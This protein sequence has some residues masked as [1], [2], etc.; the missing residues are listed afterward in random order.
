M[1]TTQLHN[2]KMKIKIIIIEF[3]SSSH[4]SLNDNIN[5]AS[6]NNSE[7]IENIFQNEYSLTIN[8]NQE[9]N[10]NEKSTEHQKSM[11]S[12]ATEKLI[13]S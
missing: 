12:K 3:V 7:S 6:N 11:S 13:M 2:L 10:D 4:K 1:M 5:A 8:N 9:N